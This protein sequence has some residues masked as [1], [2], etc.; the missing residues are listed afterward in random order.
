MSAPANDTLLKTLYNALPESAQGGV[1]VSAIH[2]N[3][4]PDDE[5][6]PVATLRRYIQWQPDYDSLGLPGAN[7]LFSGLRG[8]GKTTELNRLIT[9]LRSD[10]IAAYYCDVSR[11]LNLNDPQVR[12]SD[13]LMAALAGLADAVRAELGRDTLSESIWQRVARLLG[14]EVQLKPTVEVAL[15]SGA[16][17]I[18]A[19]LRDNPSFR[20]RLAEFAQQSSDFYRE[21]EAFAREVTRLIRERTDCH[22]IVLVVD[23]LERLS[24]PSGEESTLFDS[25]KQI[26]FNDPARL[27]LPGLSLV[28]SAPPY[29]HAILPGVNGGFTQCLSLPNFKVIERPSPGAR[30][31]VHHAPGIAR[32][33]EI[34]ERRFA[35]WREVLAPPVLEHLACLSGGNV[36]RYFALIRTLAMKAALAGTALPISTLDAEPLRAAIAEAGLPLQWLTARD[37]HWLGLFMDGSNTPASHIEDLATDLPSII[38]L[39][40][41]SLVLDYRNGESWYQVPALVRQWIVEP[42][43][44]D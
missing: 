7:Y 20:Q 9:E 28:Y 38:R 43:D 35:R 12:L 19:S 34:V 40:D 18:E 3:R 10:G 41:H 13:L 37:R 33:V 31:P 6:D 42:H 17:S 1:D 32:M 16:V 11:Y 39:F 26:F 5:H 36:R 24:A 23:S 8:V 4:S 30:D 44:P 21:A 27:R 2:V 14:S 29:L 15:P 22:T 25:L